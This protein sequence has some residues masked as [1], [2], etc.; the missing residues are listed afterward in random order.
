MEGQ[1]SSTLNT[2][3]TSPN[4]PTQLIAI[5]FGDDT[6][7]EDAFTSISEHKMGIGICITKESKKSNA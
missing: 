2:S 6:S 5:Y 1:I 3:A 4:S 7:D